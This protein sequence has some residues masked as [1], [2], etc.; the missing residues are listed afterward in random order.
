MPVVEFVWWSASDEFLDDYD[1]L[2]KP[3]IDHV[4]KAEGC[5]RIFTGLQEQDRTSFWMVVVWESHELHQAM[6]DRP[7]Y[8]AMV[9][10][11]KPFFRDGQ[12]KMNHV[13][14]NNETDAAFNAPLTSISFLTLKDGASLEDLDRLFRVLD[15]LVD[16]NHGGYPPGAWGATHEDPRKVLYLTGWDS[17]QA[18]DSI[19]QVENNSEKYLDPVSDLQRMADYQR[20]SIKLRN[21]VGRK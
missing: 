2:F 16:P 18:H 14:F 21:H 19:L 20:L 15:N 6:M 9:G 10:R 1:G 3:T 13:E 11:L 4:S 7:D 17:D 5:L 8:P 12:I